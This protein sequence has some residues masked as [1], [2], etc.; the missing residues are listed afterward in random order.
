MDAAEVVRVSW[1][2]MLGTAFHLRPYGCVY[3]GTSLA[4]TPA[5]LSAAEPADKIAM[6]LVENTTLLQ[7]L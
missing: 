4:G 2:R 1:R 5:K 7:Q 6:G 3:L